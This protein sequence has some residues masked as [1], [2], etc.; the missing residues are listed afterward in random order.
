MPEVDFSAQIKEKSFN[1]SPKRPKLGEFALSERAKTFLETKASTFN[2]DSAK[3]TSAEILAS[4]VQNGFEVAKNFLRPGISDL[5]IAVARLNRYLKYGDAKLLTS[6]P[7]DL[8]DLEY[9]LASVNVAQNKLTE[10]DFK[11]LAKAD[12]EPDAKDPAE[13]CECETPDMKTTDGKTSC[14]KCGKPAKA[15]KS[16]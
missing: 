15:K 2:E 14:S 8:L 3:E 11:A 1:F 4:V 6:E 7:V 5:Q 13:T 10:G 9:S 12:P 16:C